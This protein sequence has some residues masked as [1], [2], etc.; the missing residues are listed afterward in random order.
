MMGGQQEYHREECGL[1][2]LLSEDGVSEVVHSLPSFLR[3]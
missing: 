1:R 2:L 3:H